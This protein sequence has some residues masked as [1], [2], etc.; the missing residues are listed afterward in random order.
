M[1]EESAT[2]ANNDPRESQVSSPRWIHSVS[3]YEKITYFPF[4]THTGGCAVW[5]GPD[6][7][8]IFG[9]TVKHSKGR[10]HAIEV[11]LADA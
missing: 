7:V 1:D 2:Q 8:K 9:H 10:V 11:I 3:I 4:S 5:W 6:V